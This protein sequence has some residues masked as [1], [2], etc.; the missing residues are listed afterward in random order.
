MNPQVDTGRF[1]GEDHLDAFN[2]RI[3]NPSRLPIHPHKGKHPG[4]LEYFQPLSRRCATR[5]TNT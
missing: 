2:L 4:R 1:I 3:R 5:L